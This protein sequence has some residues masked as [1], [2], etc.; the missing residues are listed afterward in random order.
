M[1]D[2]TAAASIK[3]CAFCNFVESIS[4][5]MQHP[6]SGG[7]TAF[8]WVLSIGLIVVAIWFWSW[9]LLKLREDI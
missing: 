3:P 4:D 8:Q 1:N 6:F 7:G 9:T 5:W 2:S